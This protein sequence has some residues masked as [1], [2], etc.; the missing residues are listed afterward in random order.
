MPDLAVR[1]Q[2]QS[3]EDVMEVVRV[4]P[5]LTAE[6]INALVNDPDIRPWVAPGNEAL[7]LTAQIERQGNVLLMGDHGGCM[8]LKLLPGVYEV[9]TVVDGKHR[10]EWTNALTSACVY[11][12]FLRTDCYEILTRVPKGHIAAKAAAEARGMRYEFTRPKECNFR[13]RQID[14]AI[15]SFRIQDWLPTA[16]DMIKVGRQFHVQLHAGAE[17]LGVEDEAHADDPNHNLYVGAAVSMARFGQVGKGALLYNRWAL[18]S[19]HKPI[20]VL[21]I[22]PTKLKIDHGL[23]VTLGENETVVVERP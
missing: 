13:G 2:G 17:A 1:Y 14:V 16:T 21:G 15:H 11:W 22:N 8:F 23:V 5:Q 4:E 6:R 20:A 19:R 18:V 10:G 12:M 9:H 3:R 7:D